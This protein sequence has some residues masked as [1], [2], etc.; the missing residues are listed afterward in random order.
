V[1]HHLKR[2]AELESKLDDLNDNI[3]VVVKEKSQEII[4]KATRLELEN[5]RYKT[6]LKEV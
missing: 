4:R 6:D 2:I 5:H 3:E 1:S